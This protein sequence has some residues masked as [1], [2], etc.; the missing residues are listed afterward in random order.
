MPRI[1]TPKKFN[2]WTNLGVFSIIAPWLIGAILIGQSIEKVNLMMFVQFAWFV[3][4][5]VVLIYWLVQRKKGF[6]CPDCKT[7]IP[8]T[9]ENSGEDGEPIMH[10]CKKCDV[11]WHT[12]KIPLSG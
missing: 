12:G 1:K 8:D 10:Y 9:L 5:C 3:G 6:V 2:F 7:P 11:L 4:M